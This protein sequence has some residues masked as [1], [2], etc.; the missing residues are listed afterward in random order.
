MRQIDEQTKAALLCAFTD[1]MGIRAAADFAGVARGTA[2]RYF[3]ELD[4]PPLCKCG[5]PAT[6]QGWCSVRFAE[7]PARQKLMRKLHRRRA[8][9][10][11][12]IVYSSWLTDG[13]W[14]FWLSCGHGGKLLLGAG[15]EPL[16][17]ETECYPCWQT[18]HGI[19]ERRDREES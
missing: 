9:C 14:E 15:F 4:P 1:G 13:W 2:R 7:S 11:R 10:I 19:I 18:A 16:P 12:K 6:H 3:R 17:T 8:A 5:K